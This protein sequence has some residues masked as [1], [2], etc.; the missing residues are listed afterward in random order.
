MRK[1]EGWAWGLATPSCKITNAT[2]T[3]EERNSTL[4]G[5]GK[6]GQARWTKTGKQRLG[7]GET[8]VWLGRQDDNHQEGVALILSKKH[9]NS[10]IQW[11]PINERLLYFRLN[12]KFAKTSIVVGYVPTDMAENEDK[13]QFYFALQ[14]ALDRIPGH[15]VLLLMGDFNAKVGNNNT[16]K[17]RLW[18]GME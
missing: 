18:G 16:N 7:T 5:R 8:I 1:E 12:S 2:E 4:G 6:A 15:D 14:G 11:E 9:A 3:V 13:D 10:I 17:L